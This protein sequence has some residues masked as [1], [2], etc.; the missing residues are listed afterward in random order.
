MDTIFPTTEYV[1]DLENVLA[2]YRYLH[3]A[4]YEYLSFPWLLMTAL[5]VVAIIVWLRLVDKQRTLEI[6]LYGSW[7]A[8]T[9]VTL[10]EFGYEYRLWRYN[11]HLIAQFPHILW[12]HLFILPIIYM[13][14]YQYCPGWKRFLKIM[15]V[16]AAGLAFVGEPL[17]VK[18]D[19]YELLKWNYFYSFPL[20]ILLGIVFKAIIARLKTRQQTAGT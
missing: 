10:D 9:G 20:Y 14:I 17:L 16:C 15:T 18:L 6:L 13:L 12:V 7:I 8:I 4:K 3:W 5:T 19:Y 2:Y 1:R 11:Y